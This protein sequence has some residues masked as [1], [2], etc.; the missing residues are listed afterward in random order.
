[1]I[2]DPAL[3]APMACWP[4]SLVAFYAHLGAPW[5][6]PLK[7]RFRGADLRD[8]YD[9]SGSVSVLGRSQR[10]IDVADIAVIRTS[11]SILGKAGIGRSRRSNGRPIR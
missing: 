4:E 2:G 1:V 8:V 5:C 6:S 9:R 7:G 10:M 3:G 11:Q